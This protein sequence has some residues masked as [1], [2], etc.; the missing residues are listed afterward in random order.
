[1]IIYHYVVKPIEVKNL[2]Q[3]QFL[4]LIIGLMAFVV[5]MLA[6]RNLGEWTRFVESPMQYLFKYFGNV[7]SLVTEESYVPH[8]MAMIT[9]FSTH[10][11]GHGS[12]FKGL[13]T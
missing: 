6:L 10:N 2:L 3:P 8:Y 5:T 1:M 9:Y 13:L 7:F 4:L 12:S 11:F